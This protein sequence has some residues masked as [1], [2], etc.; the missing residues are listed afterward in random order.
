Y[1]DLAVPNGQN[2]GYRL[3]QEDLD[4]KTMYSEIQLLPL[5][6]IDGPGIYSD[7]KSITVTL[8]NNASTIL[9]HDTEGR[10]IRQY[11]PT[12]TRQFRINDLPIGHLYYISVR[13]DGAT[14]PTVKSVFLG[15]Q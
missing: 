10:T 14:R 13:E 8:L 4:G 6:T 11:H 12:A 7:G 1:N 15:G 9:V 5:K 2:I 3:K